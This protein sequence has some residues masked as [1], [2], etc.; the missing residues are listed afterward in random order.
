MVDVLSA[1]SC[2][3]IK[4]YFWPVGCG[5]G[6][7]IRPEEH[8]TARRAYNKTRGC[9]MQ[10]VGGGGSRYLY[11]RAMSMRRRIIYIYIYMIKG[12]RLRRMRVQ[13]EGINFSVCGVDI[14]YNNNNM[15]FVLYTSV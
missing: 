1:C 15:S 10:W 11:Y 5:N 4:R 8:L 13:D 6:G 2:A 12:Q 9:M 7:R 3:N 14:Q